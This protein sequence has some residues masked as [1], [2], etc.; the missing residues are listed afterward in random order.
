MY[1]NAEFKKEDNQW[2]Q[3]END[4]ADIFEKF[5]YTV[6]RDVR[7][8]TSRRF[9]IDFIAYDKQ[10]RFFVDC[11]NHAYIPPE[12]EREFI[13]K[14]LNRAYNFIDKEKKDNLKEVVLLVTKNKT[15][16]LLMHKPG[17]DKV[18]AVDISSLP[19]LLRSIDL[20]EDELFVF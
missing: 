7:F 3:F 9:Q 8:K 4:A 12:K 11:K 1:F 15:N 10:R 14:Q 19:V 6:R 5:D 17:E 16:S 20:Y 13:K 18:L 2:K